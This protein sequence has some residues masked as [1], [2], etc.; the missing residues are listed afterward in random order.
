MAKILSPREYNIRSLAYYQAEGGV[1]NEIITVLTQLRKEPKFRGLPTPAKS[2]NEA[3]F[4]YDLKRKDELWENFIREIDGDLSK[5]LVALLVTAKEEYGELIAFDRYKIIGERNPYLPKFDAVFES[6]MAKVQ[7]NYD[8]C[9]D[10][11]RISDLE[12]ELKSKEDELKAKDNMLAEA[13][14]KIVELQKLVDSLKVRNESKYDKAL[15]RK[16]ILEYVENQRDYK[17]V[18]QIFE[19]LIYMS[20]VATDEEYDEVVGLRQKMIDDSKPT[21]HNHNTIQ[22]SN[23]FPGLVNNPNFPIGADPN[24]IVKKALELYLKSQNDGTEG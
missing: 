24:E 3:C 1:Y 19:M 2:L 5:V 17:N 8:S 20:R 16:G 7:Q 22:N 14:A 21:I 15:S 18:N 11:R 13:N 4:L 6:Y 12:D 23:V 9:W 10:M